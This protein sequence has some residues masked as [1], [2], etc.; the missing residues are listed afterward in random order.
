MMTEKKGEFMTITW[1]EKGVLARSPRP[2]RDLGPD[3]DVPMDVVRE[4]IR[5]VKEAGVVSVICLLDEEQLKLYEGICG[6]L[7]EI[8]RGE[9]MNVA[10]VPIRDYCQPPLTAEQLE[11]IFAQ[12]CNLPKPVLIHCSAGV[13]RTG[14]AVDYIQAKS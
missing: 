4:W 6:D 8:Y 14:L 2:G 12:Y 3:A 10:H 9:G 7:I 11:L 13:D 5:N 1:V